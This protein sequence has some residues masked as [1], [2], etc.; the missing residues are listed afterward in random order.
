MQIV[1]PR[2]SPPRYS[3]GGRNFICDAQNIE[4]IQQQRLVPATVPCKSNP[5][6]PVDLIKAGVGHFEKPAREARP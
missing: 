4:N 1:L 2:W 6:N 5:Q 3:G